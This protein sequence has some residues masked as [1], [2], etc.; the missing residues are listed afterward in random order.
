MT[1]SHINHKLNVNIQYNNN[2]SITT[3]IILVIEAGRNC[4][5]TLISVVK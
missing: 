1:E 5:V 2:I 3:L 4:A